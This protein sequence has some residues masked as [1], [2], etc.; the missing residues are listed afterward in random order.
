MRLVGLGPFRWPV[1]IFVVM[2][3]LRHCELVF[4]LVLGVDDSETYIEVVDS[5]MSRLFCAK[6]SHRPLRCDGMAAASRRCLSK[7]DPRKL[8]CLKT[9]HRRDRKLALC[10]RGWYS[11]NILNTGRLP[12]TPCKMYNAPLLMHY[13]TVKHIWNHAF[14]FTATG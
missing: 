10:I 9:C 11:S 6:T 7:P 13:T 8:L 1:R 4:T 5:R 12:V 2:R 14:P 3:P